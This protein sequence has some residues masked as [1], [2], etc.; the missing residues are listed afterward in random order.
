MGSTEENIASSSQTDVEVIYFGIED[1]SHYRPGGFHPVHLKDVLGGR[2]RVTLKLGDGGQAT[3]WLCR[4]LELETWVAVKIQDDDSS[5]GTCPELDVKELL[6]Q[7]WVKPNAREN[8]EFYTA[9]PSQVFRIE[10][11]NGSHLCS[12]MPVLGPNI[13]NFI[14]HLNR[15]RPDTAKEL[16]GQMTEALG[17]F[18]DLGVCHGD[19]RPEN[20]VLR[21]KE[22]AIADLSEAQMIAL[23]GEPELVPIDVLEDL[24]FDEAC[25]HDPQLRDEGEAREGF[26]VWQTRQRYH[27]P[28]YLVRSAGFD[29]AKQ[30]HSDLIDQHLVIIDFGISY[31][32]DSPPDFCGI[33]PVWG[34]PECLMPGSYPPGPASDVWSL[35]TSILS[36]MTGLGLFRDPV[37]DGTPEGMMRQLELLFGPLPEEYV[38]PWRD[39]LQHYSH[40]HGRDV[41]RLMGM[42][43]QR[44]SEQYTRKTSNLQP[45]SMTP[46][47]VQEHFDRCLEWFHTEDPMVAFLMTGLMYRRGKN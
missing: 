44:M 21:L 16:C 12:V 33:P 35:G 32:S 9:L 28:E 38:Y 47:E 27:R 7:E 42:C 17:T 3:V 25:G 37:E 20:M 26:K 2:Y 24:E 22:N 15:S 6:R 14:K 11:P 4:D 34:A 8:F 39:Y 5:H 43:K 13:R 40:A 41:G 45:I 10:G 31:P 19:F 30:G 29:F 46:A 1:P 18:H 36:T 23:L